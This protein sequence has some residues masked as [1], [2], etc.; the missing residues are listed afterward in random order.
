MEVLDRGKLISAR[1]SLSPRPIEGPSEKLLITG[2]SEV[3][4][5]E[6]PDA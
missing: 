1:R 3:M 5:R 2:L 6:L 4:K